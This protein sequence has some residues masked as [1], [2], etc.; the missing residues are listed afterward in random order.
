M[1]RGDAEVVELSSLA[2][3]GDHQPMSV[4]RGR[5]AGPG[6]PANPDASSQPPPGHAG[7]G[8]LTPEG[9]VHLE[10]N[11]VKTLFRNTENAKPWT[12]SFRPMSKTDWRDLRVRAKNLACSS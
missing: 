1:G 6:R 8:A 7:T 2:P 12:G 10:D 5:R 11:K 4:R 9:I 3:G